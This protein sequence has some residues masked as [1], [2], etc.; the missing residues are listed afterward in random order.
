MA[1]TENTI[2][3][4]EASRSVRA[5]INI[6]NGYI[7]SSSAYINYYTTSGSASGKLNITNLYCAQIKVPKIILLCYRKLMK[8]EKPVARYS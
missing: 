6:T 2:D 3:V 8:G 5:C 7:E 1:V 4:D